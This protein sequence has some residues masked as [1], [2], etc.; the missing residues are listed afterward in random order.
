VF[1]LLLRGGRIVDGAGNP[2]FGGDLA[3]DG[4]RIAAIGRLDGATARRVL[5]VNGQVIC[6]G[7]I[8][9]HNH[10]EVV[11]LEN[12]RHDAKVRQGVT[13]EVLG[14]D[15]FG[16]APCT[17]ESLAVLR[18]L[19]LGWNGDPEIGWEWSSVAEFLARFDRRVAVNVAHLV[20]HGT[21]RLTVLGMEARA[22]SRIELE[23]MKAIVAQAMR[24]GSVGLSVGLSY[25]PAVYADVNE[26]VEL[27]RVIEPFGGF[28]CAHMRNHG[29]T[30]SAALEETLQIAREAGIPAHVNH[31]TVSYPMNRGLAPRLLQRLEQARQAGIDVTADVYPYLAGSTHLIGLFPSWAQASGPA[32][33]KRRLLDPACREQIRQEL[34]EVGCDGLHGVPVDWDSIVVA[35]T[36]GSEYTSA[37]G[38]S[39]AASASERGEPAFDFVCGLL[40]D[41]NLAV[42][43][44]MHIGDEGNLRAVLRYPGTM[45]ASDGLLV[46]ERPHP[47]SYGTFPR[48]FAKYVR[49]LGL[50]RLEDAVRKTVACFAPAWPPTWSSSTQAPSRTRQLTRTRAATPWAFST[51]WSTAP[52]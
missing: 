32:E 19:L 52:W 48:V 49:E 41:Q 42:P 23:Q 3:V 44:I 36:S 51:S 12:P 47:R 34:E 11:L 4:D 21:V 14:P 24:D 6:P 28:Y 16:V 18:Q 15:G 8:D 30:I 45:I 25:A 5:E 2:W 22:P 10:S 27:G 20:P 46:G 38:R 37:V 29:A 33:V 31:L 35:G 7:F 9:I 50:L 26:L 39:V 17:P 43:V 40:L 1:D 13:T